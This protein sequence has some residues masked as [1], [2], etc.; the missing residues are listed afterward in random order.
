MVLIFD[1]YLRQCG[2]FFC[3][4]HPESQRAEVLFLLMA[5]LRY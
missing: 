1:T 2:F 3:R 4:T 5:S